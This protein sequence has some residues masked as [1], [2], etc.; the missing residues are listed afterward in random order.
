MDEGGEKGRIEIERCYFV[1]KA[2]EMAERGGGVV[3]R[4][5]F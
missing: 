5:C 2:A 1:S 3:N 4:I